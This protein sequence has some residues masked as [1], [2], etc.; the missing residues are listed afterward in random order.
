MKKTLS[1]IT[2]LVSLILTSTTSCNK[3]NEPT[4]QTIDS[5]KSILPK[6]VIFN[7]DNPDSLIVSFKYDTLNHK[8]ELYED[9]PATSNL[10]DKLVITSTFNN[11]GYLVSYEI[12]TDKFDETDFDNAVIN[13]NRASKNEINYIAYYDREFNRKDTT[14]YTY[15]PVSNGTKITTIGYQS[16]FEDTTY[17]NYD[18]ENKLLSYQFSYGD[19]VN[20]QFYYNLN[21]SLSKIV[22]TGGDYENLAEFSYTSGL[23][24]D[25][26]NMMDRILLGK[27]YYLWDL[28]VLS[29]F[30]VY[31]DG[32]FDDYPLSLTDP[33]HLTRMQDTHRPTSFQPDG[34]EG[35]NISYEL[36]ENKL[37]SKLTVKYDNAGEVEKILFKY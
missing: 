17:Y 24:D 26:E 27:D 33:Y 18:K 6:Q 7:S 19:P 2:V 32:D 10:Y 29:P 22:K 11:D 21:G 1:L 3:G 4:P 36:N 37:L 35:L 31:L 23:P 14:F 12:N 25:K 15:E 5:V 8:V 30:T 13:L 16:Y 20:S 28:K 34:K 9:D